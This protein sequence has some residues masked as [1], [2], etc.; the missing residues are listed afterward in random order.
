MTTIINNA[1][2][3]GYKMVN[4]VLQNEYVQLSTQCLTDFIIMALVIESK[5]ATKKLT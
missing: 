1:V 3:F 5:K 2:I 4:T